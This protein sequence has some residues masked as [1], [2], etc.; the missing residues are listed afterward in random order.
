MRAK[1]VAL[2]IPTAAVMLSL[3]PPKRAATRNLLK[4]PGFE[5]LNE[6]GTFPAFWGVN[7]AYKGKFE[8]V[9][10]ATLAH[11]GSV[12]LKVSAPSKGR[13]AALN[14]GRFPVGPSRKV[15]VSLWARGKGRLYVFCYLYG[16]GR[17]LRSI[18]RGPIKVDDNWR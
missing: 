5:R 14:Q 12:C 18:S 7:P 13:Q 17:F 4:N 16:Q 1:A 6:E 15:Y 10:D 8:V 9:R 2:L 11:R 3:C